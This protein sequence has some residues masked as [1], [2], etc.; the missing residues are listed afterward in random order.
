MNRAPIRLALLGAGR[1]ARQ[2]L[3]PALQRC[4]AIQLVALATD[5]PDTATAVQ[6][7]F[8][9][10]TMV[11]SE[12]ILERDDI[13]AVLVATP[14]LQQPT[15]TTL[16]LRAGKHVFCE[17]P[18]VTTL[19][20]IQMIT[21]A[22]TTSGRVLAYGTCLRYAPIYQKLKSLI[23]QVRTDEGVVLTARYYPSS[24]IYDLALFLLGDVA[25]ITRVRSGTQPVVLLD[26][27]SGDLGV[28]HGINPGNAGVPLEQVEMN[29]ARGILSARGAR[30]LWSYAALKDTDIFD[31]TFDATPAT[32]WSAS[33]SIPYGALGH[34]ALR[35]YVPELEYFAQ[36]IQDSRPSLSGLVQVEQALRLHHAITRSTEQR[37][38]IEVE[39]AV[40]AA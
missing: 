5:H 22:L 24:H 40:I 38:R 31:L 10:P 1:H 20:D 13:D 37:C 2:I 14:P 39:P 7:Q 19:D 12:Q 11:G 28:I 18:G 35:G 17:T 26:F 15:L 36:T 21:D 30:E 9:L 4:H 34:L 8:A 3:I 23:P 32:I 16:A 25:A 29:S 27:T 6:A 33:S